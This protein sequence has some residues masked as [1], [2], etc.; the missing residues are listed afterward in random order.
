MFEF[1]TLIVITGIIIFLIFKKVNM[2]ELTDD[3]LKKEL[4]RRQYG[5]Y[6]Y[7]S[8]ERENFEDFLINKVNKTIDEKN[9]KYLE[10]IGI[11][12]LECL[13]GKGITNKIEKIINETK[14]N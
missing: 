5:I 2:Y 13:Y 6:P 3:E 10:E 7:K 8:I 1:S 11:H 4:L 9:N 12:A 14:K